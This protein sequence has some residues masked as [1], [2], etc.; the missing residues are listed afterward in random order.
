MKH[1]SRNRRIQVMMLPTLIAGGFSLLMTSASDV[2]AEKL[3]QAEAP[4]PAPVVVEAVN[5]DLTKQ[6]AAALSRANAQGLSHLGGVDASPGQ[7]R[8]PIPADEPGLRAAETREQ[9]NDY[10]RWR[11]DR[12]LSEFYAFQV[13]GI[14]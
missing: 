14:N 10:L 6:V 8:T 1:R 11:R 5:P 13:A 3:A 7:H 2:A 12:N 9:L 4:Q